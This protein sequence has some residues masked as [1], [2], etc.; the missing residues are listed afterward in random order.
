MF[1]GSVVQDRDVPHL[2]FVLDGM[3][4]IEYE[5]L[6][7][8]SP[9]I[10]ADT[11][12]V[13]RV[14]GSKADAQHI[15]TAAEGVVPSSEVGHCGLIGVDADLLP[16]RGVL[17]TLAFINM[18]NGSVGIK[19]CIGQFVDGV[20]QRK[21]LITREK[22]EFMVLDVISSIHDHRDLIYG[23]EF[24]DNHRFVLC[25][26][27]TV[28]P[29]TNDPLQDGLMP[30]ECSGV[31]KE[32][33]IV[34]ENKYPNFPFLFRDAGIYSGAL[35][36][37]SNNTAFV[38]SPVLRGLFFFLGWVVEPITLERIMISVRNAAPGDVVLV[39]VKEVDDRS[40]N[41][42]LYGKIEEIEK[43]DFLLNDILP[44]VPDK[45]RMV[46]TA[47]HRTLC[48]TGNHAT[49]WVPLLVKS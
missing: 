24:Y 9:F 36:T 48:A 13:S 5:E 38:S 25:I 37:T 15:L 40:H 33:V 39:N 26:N 17:E 49:G 4:D 11:P 18:P 12:N 16:S 27:T 21:A 23:V 45:M 43:F 6:N 20:L 14:F 47:D 1:R 8:L 30:T 41:R 42:D 44:F 46:L 35:P 28:V 31:L 29:K 7:S 19:C 10:Y 32:M 3:G 34:A 2:L 22:S